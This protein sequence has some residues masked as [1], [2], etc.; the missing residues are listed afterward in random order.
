[1]RIAKQYADSP[2]P[3][4]SLEFLLLVDALMTEH[5]NLQFP[6]NMGEA[7]DLYIDLINYLE[8]LVH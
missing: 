3:P 5:N 7:Q 8:D 1:M 2:D 4:A 6:Q